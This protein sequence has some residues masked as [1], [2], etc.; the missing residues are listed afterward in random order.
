M[1]GT[2]QGITREQLKELKEKIKH[3]TIQRE[4]NEND[5]EFINSF[6]I[7]DTGSAGSQIMRGI[8]QGIAKWVTK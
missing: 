7:G 8:I 6:K 4:L 5:L 1:D 3:I 2:L